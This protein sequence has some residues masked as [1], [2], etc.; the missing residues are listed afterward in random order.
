MEYII[1]T[2]SDGF[3]SIHEDGSIHK[4]ID[5]HSQTNIFNA[6][7]SKYKEFDKFI[8]MRSLC[9]HT[10]IDVY[11]HDNK[12][13]LP[14]LDIAKENGYDISDP[15]ISLGR[16]YINYCIHNIKYY[17]NII[18]S[19][20]ILYDDI[21]YYKKYV[22]PRTKINNSFYPF[23]FKDEKIKVRFIETPTST[24]RFRMEERSVFNPL[25]LRKEDRPLVS[26]MN[27]D[28]IIVQ[29]DFKAIEFR[30]AMMD[31]GIES[32]SD[33]TDPYTHMSN[34]IGLSGDRKDIKNI[35]ISM[36]YGKK[37]KNMD[38]DF[39]QRTD[40]LIWYSNNLEKPKQLMIEN[41]RKQIS[42]NGYFRTKTGRRVYEP[43]DA[44]D[45][46]IINNIFQSEAHDI[47]VL[48]FHT[49]IEECKKSNINIKPL[50]SIHDSLAI[51]CGK[52]EYEYLKYKYSKLYGYPVEWTLFNQE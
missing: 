43:M 48:S 51:E 52:K 35:L 26:P 18:K 16:G 34:L 41:C 1:K 47:I 37:F 10:G 6:N 15:H 12:K 11:D 22:I 21:E 4:N 28:N 42:D 33:E 14:L 17:K 30:I 3:V 2:K 45:Q 40:L 44:P 36:L 49:M 5:P 31:M 24:G 23:F 9:Y 8:D 39:S 27:P 13:I 32:V 29:V 25:V 46:K 19:K 38:M 20:F 50:F 7:G